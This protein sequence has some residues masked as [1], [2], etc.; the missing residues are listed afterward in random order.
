MPAYF[1]IQET[2][3]G[4]WV[5]LRLTGE[6]DLGSA[7]VLRHRLAELRAEKRLVRLDL[8]GLEFMDSGGIHLLIGAF[9]DAREDGWQLAIDSALYPQVHRLFR[10]AALDSIIP[11]PWHQRPAARLGRPTATGIHERAHPV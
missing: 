11:G 10:L 3:D 1:E 4:D 8:S 7:P 5:R 2:Y 9:N 6:L